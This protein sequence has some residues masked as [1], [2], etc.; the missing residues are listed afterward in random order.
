[1]KLWLYLALGIFCAG[2]KYPIDRGRGEN[3]ERYE[4]LA[5]KQWGLR[6][7][8]WRIQDAI[9]RIETNSNG[10]GL[11]HNATNLA[12]EWVR[13][14][15]LPHNPNL[16]PGFVKLLSFMI[17][18]QLPFTGVGLWLLARALWRLFS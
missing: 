4:Y 18:L 5:E 3:A 14:G 8:D 2:V 7:A 9:R 17:V 6:S 11:S 1:M 10:R 16:G 13:W 12:I 15:M